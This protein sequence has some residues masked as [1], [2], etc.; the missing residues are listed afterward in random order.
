MAHIEVNGELY[1]RY[2]RLIKSIHQSLEH[3]LQ[4]VL[5]FYRL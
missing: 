1:S 5:G 4:V 2:V 3:V